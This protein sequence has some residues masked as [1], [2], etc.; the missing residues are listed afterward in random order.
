MRRR[1]C[2]FV[3]LLGAPALLRAQAPHITRLGDPSVRAD[4]IYR[5]A[6]D[7]ASLPE[8]DAAFLLDDG[9]LRLEADG[10]GTRTYRQIVQI[11]KQ[12]AVERY[13]ERSF[14]WSPGHERLTVNW[15][16]VVRPD[17]SVVSAKPTHEQ[18]SDVPAS[19][20]DP[21]YTDRRV[22]RVSLS[23]VAP[24]T[25]VDYSVTTEELRPFLPRDFFASWSVS[26]GLQVTRS[27]YVVDLPASLAPR[28]LERNLNFKRVER[29]HGGRRVYTWATGNV[30]RVKSE[31][32][33]ADSNDV[34]MSLQMSSPIAWSD[35]AHWYA[36]LA[37]PQVVMTPFV[38][39][40]VDSVVRNA[41]SRTDS[42]RAVHKWVAQDIRYVAIDLGI[43]GYQP[44]S[45][46][47]VV[48]TGYGDCKDKASLFVAALGRLGI[49]AHPV[50]L[51]STGG[52][53]RDMPSIHQ[54]DHEI[55]AIRDG[56][57]W[58]FVDLTAAVT[59]FGALPPDEQGEFGLV[60]RPDGSSEVVT[61][62]LDSAAA[63]HMVMRFV[64]TLDSTGTVDGFY[65]EKAEGSQQYAL[66]SLFYD[67]PD[68]TQRA[69]FANSIAGK[70]FEAA[71]GDSLVGFNGRDLQA[72]PALRVR[73]R[74]GRLATMSGATMII[75]MPL[76]SM[77]MMST[78]AREIE[79]AEKRRF[80]I[81]PQK[82]WGRNSTDTE[83]LLTIPVGWRAEL[84]KSV[85]AAGKFGIYRS[86]YTQEGNVL[87]LTRHVE[88]TTGVQPPEAVT[89]LTAWL[90]AVGADD[91]KMIVLTRDKQ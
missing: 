48:R 42:I 30:P 34:Y 35:I 2:S 83:F 8:Q 66:R 43:G 67:P 20:D 14:S 40:R 59:P 84:P 46:E 86:E 27:R 23:G 4:S 15:I 75:H 37:R 89:E 17:G 64:G 69:Q 38:A 11:L 71:E 3:L 6:V 1:F 85:S 80:P 74:H 90:R 88:G 26:T 91:A 44:R 32:L 57:G 53:R 52:V 55:A 39:A 18:E 33:A 21:V 19:T 78:A 60:V 61:L 7:P 65:E 10:R 50:L 29:V 25:I 22:R 36:A 9:V 51:N 49:E 13:Q 58:Q 54:L 87:R 70:L 77:A 68:S 56:N 47:K 16:R 63:N 45:P 5:L 81:D 31:V 72:R 73:V 28:I 76:R 82:F 62:P 24:G 41:R 79:T 12:S